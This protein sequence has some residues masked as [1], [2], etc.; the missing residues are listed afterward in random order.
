MAV[1]RRKMG[2]GE[3]LGSPLV[4]KEQGLGRTRGWGELRHPRLGSH[5]GG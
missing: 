3:A 2:V 5:T 1:G 4:I